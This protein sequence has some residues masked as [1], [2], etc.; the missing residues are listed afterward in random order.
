MAVL[1][2]AV[3]YMN[4]ASH[5]STTSLAICPCSACSTYSHLYAHGTIFP[6]QPFPLFSAVFATLVQPMSLQGSIIFRVN[7]RVHV[8]YPGLLTPVF[9][10]CS[11]NA[12]EGLVKL[13]TC[14]D[15]PGCW[16]DISGSCPELHTEGM[17]HFSTCPP[18]I[19]VCHYCT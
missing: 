6:L 13:V 14:S 19:Q 1:P 10:A 9:V 4:E 7:N 5:S 8:V 3:V 12:W 18:S 16:V 17:C 15:V 2:Y 11:T